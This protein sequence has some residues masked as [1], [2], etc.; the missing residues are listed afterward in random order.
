METKE[1]TIAQPAD[2]IA[3]A[4]DKGLGVDELGNIEEGA[5]VSFKIPNVICIHVWPESSKQL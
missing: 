4:I 1:L 3:Q 2:L 5:T